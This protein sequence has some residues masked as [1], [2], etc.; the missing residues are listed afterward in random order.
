MS[1]PPKP[2]SRESTLLAFLQASLDHALGS[3]REVLHPSVYQR[4]LRQIGE[5]IG[6]EAYRA[7]PGEER[8]AL[9]VSSKDYLRF[10]SCLTQQAGWDCAVREATEE[11]VTLSVPVCPFGQL[12]H[13]DPSICHLEA[14]MLGGVAADLFGQ[15]KV[16][17]QRG[18]G[19]TPT[20]CRLTVYLG[21]TQASRAAEGLL[22]PADEARPNAQALPPRLEARLAELSRRERE[23]FRLLGEG[24]SNQ[25]IADALRLSVRTV[26]GHINRLRGKLKVRGRAN[27]TYLAVRH[28]LRSS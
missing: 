14:G 26:E 20:H 2:R 21:E 4:F 15:S 13:A 5:R 16:S 19:E 10:V 7:L 23:V 17:I 6:R 12:P 25:D 3:A 27:L 8:P 28:R 11:A 9:P 24:L 18:E 1:R 22:Y